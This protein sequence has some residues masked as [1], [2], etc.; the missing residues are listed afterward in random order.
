MRYLVP[1]SAAARRPVG[2]RAAA[3]LLASVT[4]AVWLTGCSWITGVPNVDRV[5]VVVSPPTI[6]AGGQ[7][8]AV[9][10]EALRDDGSVITHTRRIVSFRSTNP[11]VATVSGSGSGVVTG[12]TAGT[13]WIVGESGGK[14]D[15]AQVTVT[16]PLAPGIQIDP[17][18]PRVRVGGTASVAVR[19]IGTN[20][21]PLTG[22]TLACQSSTP[23]VLNATASGTNCAL[24]GLAVGTAVLR[25]TVNGVSGA[26]FN[27]IVENE[28]PARVVP[29]IRSPVRETERVAVGVELRRADDTIIPT[30]GRTF[31]YSSS[32]NSVLTVDPSGVLSAVREGQATVTVTADNV[33][34]TAVVRVTKIPVVDLLLPQS[35]FFRVGAQNG[36]RIAPIDS[37]NRELPTAGRLLRYTAGDP[38]VLTISAAG[39]I[40][41]L[42]EGTTTITVT[43]DSI[44]RTT[45]ATVTAMP[46][47][48]VDIDSNFVERNPGG[49][50]QYTATVLDSLGRRLTDRRIIWQS[51]N[52]AVVSIN[53]STGLARAETPGQVA[54]QAIVERVPGFPGNVVDQGS[55]TVFAAPVARVEVAPSSVT[56]RVGGTTLVSLLARDAAGNQLFGRNIQATSTNPGVAVADGTGAVRGLSAGT[57]TIRVQAVDN[58]GQPQ[59]EAAELSVT[60]SATAAARRPAP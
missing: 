21:Q 27:V 43:V 59:G 18:F 2:P 13:A 31:T 10:G 16:P 8:A 3:R 26:D 22:F 6:S 39:L 17:S 7:A 19:P 51:Q 30:T 14:R 33:T 54:I 36:I 20:G 25:V 42:K 41:P 58:G 38:T 37:L 46:V 1:S 44:T 35:L 9:I 57:T 48:I 47:G 23:A 60:V 40:Q 11:T 15:S 50:F 45:S 29:V 24:N 52:S 34:G 49:T 55:F 32:D 53:A 4:A 56:V 12:V 5:S 28:A